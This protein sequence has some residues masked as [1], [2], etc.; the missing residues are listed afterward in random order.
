ME[1]VQETAADSAVNCRTNRRSGNCSRRSRSAGRRTVSASAGSEAERDQLKAQAAENLDGWQRGR[2]EFANYK[3]RVEAERT[4]LAASA[5]AEA[6]KRVLPAVDDF[7][8]AMQTL[9]DDLKDQSVDQRRVDGAAQTER[10]AGAIGHYTDCG[11]SRRCLRSQRARSRHAR[12]FRSIRQRADH[13]RSAAR[14]QDWAI[15]SCDRRWSSRAVGV[16][17][18]Y[19]PTVV[20]EQTGSP[21]Q[22]EIILRRN[23]HGQNYRH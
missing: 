14:V 5:G 13:R 18:T 19:R 17:P 7:E 21:Q 23:N 4:E 15:G 16:D 9:P 3:R 10:R 11:E 20:G 12:R 22:S 2:A 8:R 1:A 6:L